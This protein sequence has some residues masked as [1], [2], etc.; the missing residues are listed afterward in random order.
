[1]DGIETYVNSSKKQYNPN[2]LM[3]I[4]NQIIHLLNRNKT[5]NDSKIEND[6]NNIENRIM[7]QLK[8]MGGKLESIEEN[9]KIEEHNI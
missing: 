3:D 5:A 1:M 6:S 9:D 7:Q 2:N 4:E 8:E